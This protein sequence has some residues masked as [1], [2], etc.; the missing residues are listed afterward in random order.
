MVMSDPMVMADDEPVAGGEGKV[1]VVIHLLLEHIASVKVAVDLSGTIADMMQ[2]VSDAS[3]AI[4]PQNAKMFLQISG[5][6]RELCN[7]GVP[8][9]CPPRAPLC[10]CIQPL[11]C[12]SRAICNHP[13]HGPLMR[14]RHSGG[15][16]YSS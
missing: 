9:A 1:T 3:E 12:P 2:G 8:F 6:Y 11:G 7:T 15:V 5:G 16:W 4:I 10:P 13:S 14:C